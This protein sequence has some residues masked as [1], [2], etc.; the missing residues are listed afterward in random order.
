M[1]VVA[2]HNSGRT[3]TSGASRMRLSHES[4]ETRRG[5]AKAA[6]G[7]SATE[8][9]SLEETTT[10]FISNQPRET[11]GG[12]DYHPSVIEASGLRRFTLYNPSADGSFAARERYHA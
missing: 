5:A 7:A 12:E 4:G 3:R 2:T 8:A 1:I 11:H 6:T 10:L 9:T